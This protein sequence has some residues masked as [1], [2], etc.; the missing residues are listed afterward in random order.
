[1]HGVEALQGSC[2]E[3][4]LITCVGDMCCLFVC[5]WRIYTGTAWIRCDDVD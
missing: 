3:V 1:M 5:C 4:V 2:M